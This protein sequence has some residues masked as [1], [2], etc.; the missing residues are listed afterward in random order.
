M[1][2]VLLTTAQFTWLFQRFQHLLV[3]QQVWVCACSVVPGWQCRCWQL[4]EHA[5]ECSQLSEQ[6]V[7]QHLTE[8]L[9]M[10][11]GG[12]IGNAAHLGG[13]LIGFVAFVAYRRRLW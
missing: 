11:G 13:A 12:N 4:L 2:P 9:C 1:N 5:G 8:R 10:Q 6:H 7:S 3:D